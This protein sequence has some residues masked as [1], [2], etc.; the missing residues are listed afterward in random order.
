MTKIV[1]TDRELNADQNYIYIIIIALKIYNIKLPK[2][3]I[4]SKSIEIMKKLLQ[5][6]FSWTLK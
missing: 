4:L 5:I 3:E 6:I 2:M 1:P